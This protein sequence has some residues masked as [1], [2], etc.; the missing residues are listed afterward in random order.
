MLAKKKCVNKKNKFCHYSKVMSI[1]TNDNPSNFV[2]FWPTKKSVDPPQKGSSTFLQ[3]LKCSAISKMHANFYL[4]KLTSN[5]R[6]KFSMKILK[7]R[8][9]GHH[10]PRLCHEQLCVRVYK[11]DTHVILSVS[12]NFHLKVR[13]FCPLM[14]T[15]STAHFLSKRMNKAYTNIQRH[16]SSLAKKNCKISTI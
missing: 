6:L 7:N 8:N 12:A 13:L 14:R 11:W 4:F 3:F 15:Q 9:F 2:L 1:L 5:S 10:W 16:S